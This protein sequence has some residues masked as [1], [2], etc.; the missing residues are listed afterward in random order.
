M[1]VDEGMYAKEEMYK[2]KNEGGGHWGAL[3][4]NV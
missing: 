4:K 3:E 1:Y 2:K